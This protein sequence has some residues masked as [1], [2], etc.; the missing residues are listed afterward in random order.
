MVRLWKNGVSKVST[1]YIGIIQAKCK[2]DEDTSEWA[3]GRTYK[4][5]R[6]KTYFG[7]NDK[8]LLKWGNMS[9]TRE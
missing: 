3:S 1:I 2:K 7:K 4:K 5:A 8:A 6:E 9:R